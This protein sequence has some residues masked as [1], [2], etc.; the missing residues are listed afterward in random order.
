MF[1]TLLSVFGIRTFIDFYQPQLGFNFIGP[2]SFGVLG[3]SLVLGVGETKR[4]LEAK[5][6][7]RSPPILYKLSFFFS[8]SLIAFGVALGG[9][10]NPGSFTAFADNLP[11]LAAGVLM[12]FL[13]AFIILK[14]FSSRSIASMKKGKKHMQSKRQCIC[15]VQDTKGEERQEIFNLKEDSRSRRVI[16]KVEK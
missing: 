14:I 1:L 4:H 2:L 13:T 16:E 15:L 12:V 8:L 5:R 11:Y 9:Y 3:I 10:L 7:S 6:P